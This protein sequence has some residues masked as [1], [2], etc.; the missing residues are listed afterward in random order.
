MG[1][2]GV[3]PAGS[4]S[5]LHVLPVPLLRSPENFDHDH[6]QPLHVLLQLG[7]SV[8][9]ELSGGLRCRRADELLIQ[10]ELV[11]RRVQLP[12][13]PVSWGVGTRHS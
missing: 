8:R 10:V 2:I 7:E 9:V 1:G 12:A 11:V 13:L 4:S 5:F 6:R 3:G